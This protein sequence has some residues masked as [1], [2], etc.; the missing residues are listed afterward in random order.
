M[1]LVQSLS[2]VSSATLAV[3]LIQHRELSSEGLPGFSESAAS[4]VAIASVFCPARA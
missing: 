3:P 2:A 1:D 4:I